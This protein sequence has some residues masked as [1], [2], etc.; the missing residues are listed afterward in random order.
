[1]FSSRHADAY[2]DN[3]LA[4]AET[5]DIRRRDAIGYQLASRLSRLSQ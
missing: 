5:I 4:E 2:A 1:M 3:I